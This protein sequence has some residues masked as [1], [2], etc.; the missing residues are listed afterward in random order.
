MKV[1]VTSAGITK[2]GSGNH[3]L[4]NTSYHLPTMRNIASDAP[5]ITLPR[6]P[7]KPS[8]S[9]ASGTVA[10]TTTQNFV[11][12]SQL[13]N[14]GQH[15]SVKITNLVKE[16]QPLVRAVISHASPSVTVPLLQRPPSTVPYRSSNKVVKTKVQ[17]LTNASNKSKPATQAIRI[18]VQSKKFPSKQDSLPTSVVQ[19]N[20]I[21]KPDAVPISAVQ[22][23]QISAKPKLTQSTTTQ[24]AKSVTL[25]QDPIIVQSNNTVQTKQ[26]VI[27]QDEIPTTPLKEVD[28]DQILPQIS[29]SQSPSTKSP[30]PDAINEK[31]ATKRKALTSSTKSSLS[32][33]SGKFSCNSDNQIRVAKNNS[34]AKVPSNLRASSPSPRSDNA[35]TPKPKKRHKTWKVVVSERHHSNHQNSLDPAS[36]KS[37]SSKRQNSSS[38]DTSKVNFKETALSPVAGG[39]FY[40]MII[41]KSFKSVFLTSSIYRN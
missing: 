32:K 33:T 14:S 3:L 1:K 9:S 39:K 10:T 17:T 36:T 30:G 6:I 28:Q 27:E 40:L 21:T 23:K 13:V 20:K 11:P 31:T 24:S 12:A 2:K 29:P 18:A 22:I 41:L 7:T 4:S 37:G 25:K 8:P 35:S 34:K 15:N 19:A 38:A 26:L 16:T 5:C